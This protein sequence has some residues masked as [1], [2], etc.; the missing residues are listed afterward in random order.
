MKTA[1]V[2]ANTFEPLI[3]WIDFDR[4]PRCR[5]RELF[6]LPLNIVTQSERANHFYLDLN[7]RMPSSQIGWLVL[8]DGASLL[9]LAKISDLHISPL[10]SSTG[11]NKE[12]YSSHREKSLS[13][14]V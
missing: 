9:W 14:R 12:I 8:K 3:A 13:D 1:V 6:I 11:E 7:L 10:A 4:N 5:L 2:T